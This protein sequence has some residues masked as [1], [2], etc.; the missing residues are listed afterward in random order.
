[1]GQNRH[2]PDVSRTVPPGAA[3]PQPKL[4]QGDVK[5]QSVPNR[6]HE[7]AGCNSFSPPKSC[8]RVE[9]VIARAG[10]CELWNAAA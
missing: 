9:G 5:Y 3:A 10:W 7:C 2:H 4:A 8:Q 6:G 1:M